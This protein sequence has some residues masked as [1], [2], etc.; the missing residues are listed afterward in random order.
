V[1]G[2]V[3]VNGPSTA[4]LYTFLKDTAPSGGFLG[5]LLGKDIKWNFA[6]YLVRGSDGTVVK[7]F[8]P[9]SSPLSFESDIVALLD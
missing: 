7:S 4:P 6:K 5:S 9:P 3:D 2:K 8:E 1:F